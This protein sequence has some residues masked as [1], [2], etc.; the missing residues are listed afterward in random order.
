MKFY[1]KLL[2]AGAMVVSVMSVSSCKKF[3][4]INTSPLTATEVEAKL[5]F[6]YSIT[7]WDANKNSGDL[8]MP[9]GLMIQNIASGGDEGWGKDNVYNLSPFSLGNTW[10]VYYSTAGNNLKQAITIA[11]SGE[12]VDNNTA[13]QCKI[14]LA[15]LMYEATTLY[16]DVPYTEAFN[17]TDFPAPKYDAQKD[18]FESILGLLDEAY[19]QIDEASPFKISDYDLFYRGDMSKWK[20]LAKSLKLRTLMTMVDADN[21]KAAQIGTLLADESELL[22]SADDNWTFPYYTTPNNENPKF[23]LFKTYTNE[24]NLWF[25]ANN[26][27]FKYMDP[28][29][30][31]IPKYFDPGYHGTY[32]P[33]ETEANAETVIVDGKPNVVSSL[34][35]GY[36]YRADAPSYLLTYQEIAFFK[37]EAYARGLGVTQDLAK[38]DDYYK[39]AIKAAALLYDVPTADAESF[40]NGLP[41]LVTL[42]ATDA[43]KEIHLQQWVDLMDRPLEAFTQWR[44]SGPEGSEVPVLQLPE[45]AT[46]G[47]LIRRW[48]L[49]PDEISANNNKPSP[50]PK[51]YDKMWFDL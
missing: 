29:D 15:Q 50:L 22:S 7:A 26:N 28:A 36:L 2:I 13:A 32:V 30:P 12:P 34:I 35:S 48:E 10:K 40:A 24:K 43:L 37:A 45:G 17:P 49:S 4:D 23:R 42:G 39:E 5:L 38:A 19:N 18:V 11:E 16:G 20:K 3:L 27:V 44:R 8:W 6:G 41:S 46:Q 9:L 21:T 1:N 14:V 25:F 51:Y 47:P 33:V 31:R